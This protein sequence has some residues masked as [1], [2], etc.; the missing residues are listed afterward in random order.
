MNSVPDENPK[1]RSQRLDPSPSAMEYDD[2]IDFFELFYALWK[3]RVL[4]FFCT[5]VFIIAGCAYAFM[6]PPVYQSKTTLLVLPPLAFEMSKETSGSMFSSEI[7]KDLAVANDLIEDVINE[8]YPDGNGPDISSFAD[9]LTVSVNKA[10]EKD[11]EGK[12][13]FVLTVTLKGGDPSLLSTALNSW[14]SHFLKRS[15]QIFVNRGTQSFEYIGKNLDLVRKDLED[16]ENAQATFLKNNPIDLIETRLSSI[17]T[18]YGS[19]YEVYATNTRSLISLEAKLISLKNTFAKEPEKIIL[20]RSPSNEALWSFLSDQ[21]ASKGQ[22]SHE[23]MV[24][25]DEML[26]PLYINLEDK[27][28]DTEAEVQSLRASVEYLGHHLKTL[29]EEFSEKETTLIEARKNLKI[30]ERERISLEES[31]KLLAQKY[32]ETRIATTDVAES[33]RVIEKPV[34]STT[35]VAPDK[36]LIVVLSGVLGFFVALFIALITNMIQNR[37]NKTV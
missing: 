21:N 29:G 30:M 20:K 18:L 34:L 36:K 15:A 26:N 19:L 24:F 4:I 13:P 22:A 17:K 33:I 14:I 8:T 32:Q 35:P 1:T 12:F 9:R 27:I 7:Y 6:A 16:T 31:Y 37:L 23:D 5:A 11:P 28:A 10:S 25:Q 3:Q 2:E